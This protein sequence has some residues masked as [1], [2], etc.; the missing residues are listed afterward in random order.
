MRELDVLLSGWLDDHY[1]TAGERD[2]AA[3]RALLTLPDPELA[4]Y[5]LHGESPPDEEVASVVRKIRGD[6]QA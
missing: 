2:K 1:S 4:G 6:T 3:F 5:L